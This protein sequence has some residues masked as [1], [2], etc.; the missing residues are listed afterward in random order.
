MAG[1]LSEPLLQEMNPQHGGQRIR[2]TAAFLARFGVV[3]LDQVDQRLPGHHCLHLREE[4]L[5][6]GLLLVAPPRSTF[7]RGKGGGELVIREAELRAAHHP[8]PGLR[9]QGHCPAKG[10]GFPESLYP[11][12]VNP[13]WTREAIGRD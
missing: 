2:R 3:R 13:S 5:L 11:W 8:S 10:A 7:G 6:F 4:L 1:S 12:L 9:L